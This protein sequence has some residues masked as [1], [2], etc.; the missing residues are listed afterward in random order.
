M[1]ELLEKRESLA[2]EL[3][4]DVTN[5]LW[6]G[7]LLLFLSEQTIWSGSPVTLMVGWWGATRR[8]AIP[9]SSMS[10]NLTTSKISRSVVTVCKSSVLFL[11]QVAGDLEISYIGFGDESEYS[12]Q[13]NSCLTASLNLEEMVLYTL[14]NVWKRSLV[15]FAA[16]PSSR[17]QPHLHVSG[18]SGPV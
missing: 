18:G 3:Q 2:M 1:I 6:S 8:G 15:R 4:S 7:H 10:S 16:S 11:S 14:K 9:P 13:M 17:L 5:R 12:T